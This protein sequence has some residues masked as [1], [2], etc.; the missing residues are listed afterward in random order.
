[1]G[2]RNPAVLT[3]SDPA[4][5]A[6]AA[7]ASF[8][9]Y[10]A[11]LLVVLIASLAIYNSG[12]EY[13]G[14]QTFRVGNAVYHTTLDDVMITLRVATNIAAGHGP[15]FNPGE[16]VAANT[17]LLW[18]F[19]LA[20]PRSLFGLSQT[21][22]FVCVLSLLLTVLTV[23]AVALASRTTATSA[24]AAAV[25][26]TS[27]SVSYYA[28]TGWEHVPQMLLVTVAFLILIGRLPGLRDDT[29]RLRLSVVM[30]TV[31]FLVRPDTLL[32]LAV[33]GA[34]LAHRFWRRRDRRDGAA[35]AVAIGLGALYYL[36]HLY[37][38]D[39]LVPNTFNLKVSAEGESVSHGL[40]YLLRNV[41]DGG[42]TL[43][44]LL[45]IACL[46]LRRAPRSAD[47]IVGTSLV[48]YVLSIVAVGGDYFSRGRFLLCITPIAV[49]VVFDCLWDAAGS[50]LAK[51]CKVGFLLAVVLLVPLHS[52]WRDLVVQ[53]DSVQLRP[54][55]Q[56]ADL[57]VR[58]IG[59]QLAMIP[60]IREALTP[61]DGQIGLFFLGSLSYYLPEFQFADFLGKADPVVAESPAKW[62]PV[63][64]NKW[65][66]EYTLTAHR[67]SIVPLEPITRAEAEQI[68]AQRRA[69]GAA[70]AL[71]L[72]PL[73]QSRYRYIQAQTLGL[74]P[75]MG[76]LVRND[77]VSRFAPGARKPL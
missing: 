6:N 29:A 2:R 21:V 57:P 22:I 11:K 63:A 73:A 14:A 5:V 9:G 4:P 66:I 65:D 39:S 25:I 42:N 16:Y 55:V 27:P 50:T 7:P 54:L 64:H 47:L 72:H 38:Y 53:G 52:G 77:L 23:A 13:I 32:L 30:L 3:H 17:S 18:P 40:A 61:A 49:F 34:V 56:R 20:I 62:G 71:V 15:Y 10:G 28:W 69:Y 45:S 33:P 31:A 41:T 36:A 68:V 26:V 1:M 74:G 46:F 58:P 67:V 60:V 8:E 12:F 70:A 37:F 51:I 43:L 76:L 59:A 48:L 24:L 75:E 19:L 44:V 35:L